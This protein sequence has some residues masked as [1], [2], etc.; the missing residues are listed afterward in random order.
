MQIQKEAGNIF[1]IPLFL[2]SDFKENVKSYA[3]YKFPKSEIYAFGRLIEIDQS[4]GDLVEIFKHIGN[5]PDSKDIIIK[6]GRLIDPIHVSLGFSKKR[7]QF[8][9]EDKDYDKNIDSN[10]QNITFLLGIPEIPELWQGG[11]ISRISDYDTN[12]FNEWIVYPPTKVEN[13]IKE[14]K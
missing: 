12:K 4:G 8:I 6:S 14:I 13:L 7:W 3:K 11:D 10:Y 1:S 5:I 2:S 9:F